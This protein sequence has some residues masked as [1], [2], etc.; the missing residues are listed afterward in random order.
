VQ[1]VIVSN[2]QGYLNTVKPED[3]AS[4]IHTSKIKYVMRRG[5]PYLWV[6]ESEPHNVVSL[7]SSFCYLVLNGKLIMLNREGF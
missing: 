3:K 5:K 6:P 4:I 2:W 1:T 7:R